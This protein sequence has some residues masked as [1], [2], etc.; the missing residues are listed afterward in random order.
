MQVAL[1]LLTVLSLVE[2]SSVQG[3]SVGSYVALG[4]LFNLSVPLSSG[5]KWG[6]AGTFLTAGLW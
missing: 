6:N 2:G 5:V 4:W 3:P 1:T